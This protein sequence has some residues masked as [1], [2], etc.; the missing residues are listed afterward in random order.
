M[1]K[2]RKIA[3]WFW[4]GKERM[5]LAVMVVVLCFRVYQV[6]YPPPPETGGANFQPPG[7]SLPLDVKTPGI[8]PRIPPNMEP[9]NYTL[10]W[11]RSPFTWVEPGTR[12]RTPDGSIQEVDL[13]LLNLQQVSDGS[14]RVQIRSAAN[15]KKWYAEGA[16]FESY[17]LLAIDPDT[18]CVTVFAEEVQRRAEI[19][20]K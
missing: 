12:R 3:G 6:L 17:Q 2:L 1:N 15:T 19:C 20:K 7:N 11:M 9:E 5:V 8:P 18:E 14:W 13:E 10:L 16:R 4:I